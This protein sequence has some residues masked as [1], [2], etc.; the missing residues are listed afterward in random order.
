VPA[1]TTKQSSK[2]CAVI[3]TRPNE[4]VAKKLLF[5]AFFQKRDWLRLLL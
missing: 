2:L 3:V 5:D 1:G 4:L